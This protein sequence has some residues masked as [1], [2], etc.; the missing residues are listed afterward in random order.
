MRRGI[1]CWRTIVAKECNISVQFVIHLN[2]KRC[3]PP[4]LRG[5]WGELDRQK[6]GFYE[7]LVSDI[8]LSIKTRFLGELEILS[9]ADRRRHLF[10]YF[11]H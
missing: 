1:Y 4:L 9:I 11:R 10:Q 8:K 3:K 2:E 5:V 6:P 7:T